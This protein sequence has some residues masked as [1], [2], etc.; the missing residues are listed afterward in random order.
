METLL[1]KYL[2]IVDL[3]A[4]A[5][6]ATFLAMAA[7]GAV[8]LR[9]ADGEAAAISRAK[10]VARAES[11]LA[12]DKDPTAIV[13]RNIFCSQCPSLFD[14]KKADKGTPT[15]PQPQ[16]TELPVTIMAI[17]YAAPPNGRR[18]SMAV[19]RDTEFKT[20]G[21]FRVG[22]K[23]HGAIITEILESRVYLLNQ[24]ALEYVDMLE[25]PPPRPAKMA[26]PSLTDSPANPFAQEMKKG[27]KQLGE[28][29]YE[30]RRATL[31][32]V[33]GNT[34]LLLGSVRL[35]P[36][37]KNGKATGFRL[38]AVHPEG[39]FALIGMQNGDIISSINGLEITSPEGGLAAYTKLKSASHLSLGMERNGQKV[40]KE[41]R[42]R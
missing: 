40:T 34:P 16:K 35:V 38:F 6:C 1:R 39:P 30:L 29:K 27:I 5:L 12:F 28:N 37:I 32:S 26:E 8:E 21:A 15:V 22:N 3:G 13:K 36:E 2:W 33:L 11:R 41:Y 42:I 19:L 17:M 10:P 25:P 20:S 24:G 23:V 31:E 7:S 14:D 9:L 18:W 4:I